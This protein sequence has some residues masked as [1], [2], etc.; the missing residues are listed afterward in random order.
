MGG[1]GKCNTVACNSVDSL[2]MVESI[3]FKRFCTRVAGWWNAATTTIPAVL[4]TAATDRVAAV[5]GCAERVTVF[6]G[7][8]GQMY[9]SVPG[10]NQS[11]SRN[12]KAPLS[13]SGSNRDK[14]L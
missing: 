8:A 9:T 14:S 11:L 10:P 1:A 3:V 6:T 4:C 5:L 12:K 7:L 13:T 2:V